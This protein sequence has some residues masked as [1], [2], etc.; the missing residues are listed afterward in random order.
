MMEEMMNNPDKDCKVIEVIYRN[1]DEHKKRRIQIL[2][3][4][5]NVSS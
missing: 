5:R 4:I 3:N 2:C 1:Y